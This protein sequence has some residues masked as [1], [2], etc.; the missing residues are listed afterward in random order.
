MAQNNS[1]TEPLTVGGATTELVSRI[2]TGL[3]ISDNSIRNDH[4]NESSSSSINFTNKNNT[5]LLENLNNSNKQN[6]QMNNSS[7]ISNNNHISNNNNIGNVDSPNSSG[8]S[9]SSSSSND[10]DK[11]RSSFDSDL[12]KIMAGVELCEGGNGSNMNDQKTGTGTTATTNS[13]NNIT[14]TSIDC[15]IIS[16]NNSDINEN[17][18]NSIVGHNSSNNNNNKSNNDDDDDGN[19]ESEMLSSSLLTNDDFNFDISTSHSTTNADHN[20]DFVKRSNTIQNNNEDVDSNNDTNST[21]TSSL[22]HYDL[23]ANIRSG[24]GFV[25]F[26]HQDGQ[27]TSRLPSASNLLSCR[28]LDLDRLKP[29]DFNNPKTSY[30]ADIANQSDEDLNS[31]RE[32]LHNLAAIEKSTRI[33]RK[34]NETFSISQEEATSDYSLGPGSS[35]GSATEE[36]KL[37]AKLPTLKDCYDLDER[38]KLFKSK[39]E[40]CCCMFDFAVNPLSELDHKETKANALAELSEVITYQPELIFCYECVYEEMRKIVS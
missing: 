11:E 13:N 16:K 10:S 21:N 38:E 29:E 33:S 32:D 39:V 35:V 4:S 31:S 26:E 3:T 22:Y 2:N 34:L 18:N 19:I 12:S 8:N 24:D 36:G 6:N 7:S 28:E 23:A 15:R 17:I 14:N 40:Q 37:F 27:P 9:S 1:D 20:L 30:H 25:S 5:A